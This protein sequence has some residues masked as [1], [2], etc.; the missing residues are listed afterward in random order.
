VSDYAGQSL[1]IQENDGEFNIEVNLVD[2]PAEPAV[3]GVPN[4][5]N[6]VIRNN[7]GVAHILVNG[8]KVLIENNSISVGVDINTGS[9]N[10]IKNNQI[11]QDPD[12]V[13]GFGVSIG[14]G[15][16]GDDASKSSGNKIIGNTIS[17]F[18][19]AIQI[20]PAK[21][22]V[23]EGNSIVDND[24][25]GFGIVVHN[26]MNTAIGGTSIGQRNHIA[27]NGRDGI[28]IE[29]LGDDG[30]AKTTGN[31]VIGNYIGTDGVLALGNGGSGVVIKNAA[32]NTVG[33]VQTGEG[34]LISANVGSGVVISGIQARNNKVFGNFVGTN[35]SGTLID[36]DQQPDSGDEFGNGLRGD[37]EFKGGI[38]VTDGAGGNQI[39]GDFGVGTITKCE[40]FCNV[41]SGNLF[42]I[43]VTGS[44]GPGLLEGE[45][46]NQ[47]LGNFVGVDVSGMIPLGNQNDGIVI[48]GT[49]NNV[50][51]GTAP[52]TRNVVSANGFTGIDITGGFATNNRVLGNHVGTNLD[53]NCETDLFGECEFGNHANGISIGIGASDNTIGGLEPGSRNVISGNHANGVS[54]SGLRTFGDEFVFTED[55]IVIG[56]LIGVERF[57]TSADIEPLGN[58]GDGVRIG[59]GTSGNI[60]GGNTV[61]HRNVIS[62]NGGAGVKIVAVDNG[63]A[64]FNVV[65]GNF[66]GVNADG[67][68]DVITPTAPFFSNFDAGIVIENGDG[69]TIDRTE[70]A[71][72]AAVLG[73]IGGGPLTCTDGCNVISQNST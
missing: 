20:F 18:H 4:P 61:Q 39:G 25:L 71:P 72:N 37:F 29:G 44:D 55:N 46:G 24:D 33:G 36:L 68:Q 57:V 9:N 2:A 35:D 22:T 6:F 59:P 7:V 45:G 52:G 56:N 64:T 43:I 69:N 40:N 16:L 42:G 73:G 62:A 32:G 54:I 12:E 26:S 8:S 13:G 41:V 48:S 3:L 67:S 70:V 60:I 38:L 14:T 17:K 30:A 5:P 15:Q 31:T 1:T 49:P 23:V 50:V 21:G 47:V 10:A 34:N 65:Q 51:G 19:T 58:Q 28:L 63:T 27:R 66:I 53:G 11:V